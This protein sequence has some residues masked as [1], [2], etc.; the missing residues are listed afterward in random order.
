MNIIS[1][2][3][4][5]LSSHAGWS[6]IER[7]H[8]SIVRIFTFLV[9]P[10]SLI[11]PV[12]LYYVGTSYGDAFMAG[13]GDKQWGLI[14][15]TFFLAEIITFA[16]MGWLIQQIA[17]NHDVDLNTHDAYLLAGIA[18][19]PMW[20]S[21]L[22]LLVPNLLFSA[23]VALAGLLLSCGLIYHGVFALCHM[24]EEVVA[25]SI[26]YTVIGAGLVAWTFLLAIVVVL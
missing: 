12:I 10:L 5:A 23:V 18:P 22:G 20:L 8:P 2:S 25:V 4:M 13:V 7:V 16:A 9:L 21:A 26:T 15:V 1:L 17:T 19:V 14:A 6:E 24:H 11:P 3:K